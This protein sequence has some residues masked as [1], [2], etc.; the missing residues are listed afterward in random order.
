V[1]KVNK[2]EKNVAEITNR[3]ISACKPYKLKGLSLRLGVHEATLR[4]WIKG[5]RAFNKDDLS[6]IAI[7]TGVDFHWLLT[8]EGDPDTPMVAAGSVEEATRGADEDEEEYP[9]QYWQD[10][11]IFDKWMREEEAPLLYKLTRAE[12]TMLKRLPIKAIEEDYEETYIDIYKECL[13][14]HRRLEIKKRK[15]AAKAAAVPVKKAVSK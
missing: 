3:I 7:A 1:P 2:I 4:S 12:I 14:M 9:L 15:R 5:R 6:K 13:R 11:S 10:E 8:G